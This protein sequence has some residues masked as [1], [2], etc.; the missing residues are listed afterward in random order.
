MIAFIAFEDSSIKSRV[1]RFV[2]SITNSIET[3]LKCNVEVKMGSLAELINEELTIEAGPKVRRVDSDVLSSSSSNDR[4]KG[5]LT[6]SGR[7]FEHPNEIK[8]ELERC[9]NTPAADERLKSVSVTTLNSGIPKSEQQVVHMSKIATNDE[10]RL[11]S[12]WLQGVDKQTPGVM[13]QTRDDMHPIL[14]Q[15]C[16]YQR[17]S[18]M[19]LVVPSGHAD[20]AL[21]HEIEAP[22]MVMARH[23]TK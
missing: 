18:S 3:V 8:K 17:K 12:A 20:E 1:Q 19:S 7:G 4:L 23:I 21:A 5:T 2:S 15:D 16:P 10:Q 11:E 9:K 6:S 14:S 13:N 22:K